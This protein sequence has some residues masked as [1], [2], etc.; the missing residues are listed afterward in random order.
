MSKHPT[1]GRFRRYLRGRVDESVNLGTLAAKTL[2]SAAFDETVNE[3][4]LISSVHA[5]WTMREYTPAAGDGPILVG[6]AHS[7]YT[8]AEIEEVIE[9]AG[10]WNE[11]DKV[12]QE[13]A[14]RL[15]RQVGVFDADS[16]K[17]AAGIYTLNDGMPVKTKLNWI[18]LQAQTLDLWSYNMGTS[19]LAT[20][21]PIVAIEGHANLWP[22]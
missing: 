20:T 5:I 21:A 3:R 4:T 15:V 17:T 2:V 6:L 7:D 19:P 12:S 22:Q 8:D 11:G 9:N 14:K 10:S 16:G 1:K 13:M 18:L